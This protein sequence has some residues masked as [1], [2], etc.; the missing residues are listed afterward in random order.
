[1]AISGHTGKLSF[2]PLLHVCPC[3]INAII[4]ILYYQFMILYNVESI[5]II[6]R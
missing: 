6:T 3:I 1:M 5:I 4:A 2:I